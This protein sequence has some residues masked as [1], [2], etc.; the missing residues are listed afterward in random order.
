M[1]EQMEMAM[2]DPDV[3]L[4]HASASGYPACGGPQGKGESVCGAW[5]RERGICAVTCPACLAL[6]AAT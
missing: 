3:P 5:V 1:G 2:P 6:E 4:S